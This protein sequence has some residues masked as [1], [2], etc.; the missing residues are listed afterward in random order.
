M[1]Q[2]A[3]VRP[4]IAAAGNAPGDQAVQHYLRTGLRN[5]WWP[6]L[7]SRFVETGGK[8]LGITR[9]GEPLLLWRDSSGSIHVQ[10]D[11]CPHRAVPLSRGINEGDRI[12]CNYHGVEVGPDGTVLK[13]PGQ[14]GCPLEGKKAVK[15][16]PAR[17]I[18]DA[19]FVWFGDALHEEPAALKPPPQ[20][21]HDDYS[22]ILCYA[23]WE[24]H[25]RFLYDN[26]M[27]PMH[28]TFLHANSHTMYTGD[29]KAH[30]V[31]R[32]TPTGFF[33]EKSDQ[34]DVNFD[35]SELV[36]DH[37]LYVRLEIPYPP[38]AGP[39]GN[40][41][42]ISF[43]TPIDDKHTAAFFWRVRKVEG[44]QRDTWRFLY[45]TKIEERHWAVLEQDREI[46]EGCQPGIEKHEMLY[47]HDAGVI[48]L[49][50]YLAQEA[51][52]QLAALDAAGKAP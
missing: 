25:W 39:G 31:T 47:Q 15:T 50:R 48:R 40:F 19:I 38:S 34:R 27:D 20:L 3:V 21:V 30:F 17:E 45:R 6:I 16:Y 13:V 42:I 44:W 46:L 23:D 22:R 7:P 14:P 32:D 52:R 29:T 18:A 37:A 9:L 33:F 41:A 43:G 26:N 10:T 49:R 8:P 12:R 36:D 2:A 28:G 35:W 4:R 51:S 5:R 11:R 24:T 1:T